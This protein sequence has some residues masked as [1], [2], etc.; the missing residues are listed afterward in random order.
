MISPCGAYDCP[1]RQLLAVRVMTR[2]RSRHPLVLVVD[3]DEQAR[4]YCRILLR[5]AGCRCRVFSSGVFVIQHVVELRPDAIVL[6]MLMPWVGGRTVADGLKMEA[7]TASIPLIG[8]TGD[9]VEYEAAQ[10]DG[11]F[12]AVLKKPFEPEALERAVRGAIGTHQKVKSKK[13]ETRK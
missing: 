7:H 8:I 12:V 6:D 13:L 9:D 11:G 2:P 10:R 1:N 3:D 5:L 4:E